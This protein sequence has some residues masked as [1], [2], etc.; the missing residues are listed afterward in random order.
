MNRSTVFWIAAV[1]VTIFSVI[2]QR[3]TGPTF[4]V[5]GKA[6]I[7]GREVSYRFLRSHDVDTDA[8]IEVVCADSS[9]NGV[10]EWRRYK[11]GEPW[12]RVE[13]RHTQGGLTAVLPRQPMA[14]KLEYRVLVSKG[15]ERA[16]LPEENTVVIRF[17]G[18]VP[19]PVLL[20]HIVSMFAA[21]LLS[22]R[23]GLEFFNPNDRLSGLIPWAVAC[24]A[25]G[26][27]VL[28]PVVQKY[29]FDAYWTGWPFGHDLTDNKTFLALAG[30]LCAWWA[31]GRKKHA[32]AWALGAALLMFVVYM[33]PHSVF[34][35]ELKYSALEAKTAVYDSSK[36]K[37]Q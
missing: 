19:L 2:Y 13:M 27:L 12:T 37:E 1:V 36:A 29:A 3:I 26:G 22:V 17:K 32:K 33:V 31:L 5:S 15:T 14:G 10:T 21:M 25:I 8:S 23:A 28:G 24:L 7:D 30:W 4:P 35:S 34:G 18:A 11:T 20:L 9:V 16:A 6:T